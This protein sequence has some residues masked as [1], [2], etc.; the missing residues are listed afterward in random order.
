LPT[1]PLYAVLNSHAPI[2]V[3]ETEV[4]SFLQEMMNKDNKTKMN[5]KKLRY[6]LLFSLMT[7]G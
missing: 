3:D 2:S 5:L 6:I 4:L 7:T 1:Q